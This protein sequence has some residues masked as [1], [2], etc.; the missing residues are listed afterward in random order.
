MRVGTQRVSHKTCEI[1]REPFS[2]LC[3]LEARTLSFFFF[4]FL[5][6]SWMVLT[7]CHLHVYFRKVLKICSVQIR[8]SKPTRVK[9]ESLITEKATAVTNVTNRQR[10]VL[11]VFRL[12]PVLRF[13]YKFISSCYSYNCHSWRCIC[14]NTRPVKFFLDHT[15][16]IC[17]VCNRC[18]S[19]FF[20]KLK[21]PNNK[22]IYNNSFKIL[23][24]K[25]SLQTLSKF[26]SHVYN[27]PK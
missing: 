18:L 3:E 8:Y 2:V 13:K 14:C 1:K 9:H 20:L 26:C 7:L 19:L 16:S 12:S 22:N 4:F 17:N 10:M 6:Q 21:W 11:N 15:L 5:L 24:N 23:C 27:T 25:F